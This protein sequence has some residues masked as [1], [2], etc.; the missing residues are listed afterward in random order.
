[1]FFYK[2]TISEERDVIR[3]HFQ[4]LGVESRAN[5]YCWGGEAKRKWLGKM[6][7]RKMSIKFGQI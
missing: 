3:S 4:R 7:N 2:L 5:R 6:E 1:M